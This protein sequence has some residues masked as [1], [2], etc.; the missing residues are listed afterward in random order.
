MSRFAI[1]VLCLC[2]PMVQS[3]DDPPTSLRD[4]AKAAQSRVAYGIYVKG[5]KV[6]WS[7]DEIK[8]VQRDGR[9]VMQATSESFMQTLFDGEKSTKKDK[10]TYIY[11]LDGDGPMIHADIFKE[12]DGKS[13]TR[14]GK[15]IGDKFEITTNQAGRKSKRMVSPPKDTLANQRQLEKWLAGERKPGDTQIKWSITWEEAEIDQKEIYRFKAVREHILAGVNTKLLAVEVESDGAKMPAEVFPDGKVYTADVGGL[16]TIKMEPEKVA[17]AV[18]EKLVDLMT[19]A[20]IVLNKD[21]GLFG[22]SVDELTLEI[23]EFGDFVF[24]SSHRQTIK[25]DKEIATVNLKRDFRIT[26]ATPL[27]KVEE[28]RWTRHTPRIQADE[29]P[30]REKAEQIVGNE[31]DTAKRSRKLAQWVYRT[32]KKSYADNAETALEVLER[33]AGDCTEHSLLF[34]SL[35]RSLGIP[36]REVGGLAYV[37]GSKPILGWHAW[38]EIHDGHQWISVDPTWDQFYVDGTHLKLSEGSRD[39]AWSNLA[40]RVQVKVLEFKRRGK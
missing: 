8:I 30:I 22:R 19:A 17:R 28:R 18:D 7:V 26:D 15:R 12:D 39:N 37:R 38:A 40:G 23:K 32:L 9:E 29:Q 36:A 11:S 27:T 13:I 3:A 34:V 24:P 21:L 14:E 20:S 5:K 33:K 6:G 1:L 4:W 25:V 35:C 10:T 31:K 2:V 16:L